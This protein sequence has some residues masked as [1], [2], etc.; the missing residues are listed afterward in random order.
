[1]LLID[2]IR[3]SISIDVHG[4]EDRILVRFSD[5]QGT[6]RERVEP[7][8]RLHGR[9]WSGTV[10]KDGNLHFG[11]GPIAIHIFESEDFPHIL[12]TDEDGSV[13][14]SL[15][16]IDGHDRILLAKGEPWARL[17]DPLYD[18]ISVLVLAQVDPTGG[19]I[20][21]QH[22][23]VADGQHCGGEKERRELWVGGLLQPDDRLAGRIHVSIA[24]EI[25]QFQYMTTSGAAIGDVDALIF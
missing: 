9:C 3:I 22:L 7:S 17:I 16:R 21:D 24:I 19:S 8:R 14:A 1:M 10:E 4:A 15:H 11:D 5:Q 13:A 23:T 25:L 20:G 6:T 18:S 2:G 12:I